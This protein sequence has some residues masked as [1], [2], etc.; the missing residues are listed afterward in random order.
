MDIAGGRNDSIVR[1]ALE[2]LFRWMGPSVTTFL[3]LGEG[4]AT[5]VAHELA[6]LWLTSAFGSDEDLAAVYERCIA[7]IGPWQVW[8]TEPRRRVVILVLNHLQTDAIRLPTTTVINYVE[9]TLQAHGDDER[10]LH[11]TLQSASAALYAD[12]ADEQRDHLMKLIP[13][14]R[15]K[16]RAD[17]AADPRQDS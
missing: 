14:L 11:L 6:N 12:P 15:E 7:L 1:H 9:K 5:S 3:G 13:S 10:I 17:P 2:P 4:P 8:D 16:A